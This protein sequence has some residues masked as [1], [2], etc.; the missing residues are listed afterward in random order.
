MLISKTSTISWLVY[1]NIQSKNAQVFGYIS[2]KGGRSLKEKYT[3]GKKLSEAAQQYIEAH[4]TE[5]FSLKEMADALFV[6]GSYLLRT[7]RLYTDMTPLYYHHLVRCSKAK[8][9]L[10]NTDMSITETGEAVGF[11]S[12]SHFTHIFRKMEGCTPSEY[13][14]MHKDQGI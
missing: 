2:R 8:D 11:V 3:S 1:A 14:R 9:L 12:S 6:N 13:R 4:S 10:I 5:K 7:F